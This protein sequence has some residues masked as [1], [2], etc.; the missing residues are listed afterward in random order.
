MGPTQNLCKWRQ[1]ERD[2]AKISDTRAPFC[3]PVDAASKRISFSPEPRCRAQISLL[4]LLNSI[5][6]ADLFFSIGS[7][8][9][10][11]TGIVVRDKKESHCFLSLNIHLG[12]CFILAAPF[13]FSYEFF[14]SQLLVLRK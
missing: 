14:L 4:A 3:Y 9:F 11:R 10:A 8:M 6:S 12:A 13:Y 2:L 1:I 5:K 7:A